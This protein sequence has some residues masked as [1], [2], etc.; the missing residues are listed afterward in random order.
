MLILSQYTK[1]MEMINED[2]LDLPYGCTKGIARRTAVSSGEP[3]DHHRLRGHLNAALRNPL[4][5][6]IVRQN[7][8]CGSA[9]QMPTSFEM[10]PTSE[11]VSNSFTLN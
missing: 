4:R 11:H 8:E 1:T 3:H 2:C 5:N 6:F 9:F 10:L 7:D